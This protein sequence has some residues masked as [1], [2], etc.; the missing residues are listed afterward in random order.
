M[1]LTKIFPHLTDRR[2]AQLIN[3]SVDLEAA[4]A[5]GLVPNTLFTSAKDTF[6]RVVDEGSEK[7]LQSGPKFERHNN[8]DWWSAAYANNAFVSGCH[9]INAA[10]KRAR[11][12]DDL[13]PYFEFLRDGLL[14][15]QTLLETA[16]PLVRKKADMPKQPTKREQER[17]GHEMTCQCCGRGIFA[18]TGKIAHHGYE[19][20]GHGWQTGSCVGALELPFE[21][22]RER[23]HTLITS[24]EVRRTQMIASRRK[25]MSERA[26]VKTTVYDL[27][28][29]RGRDGKHPL[30]QLEITR[31][32][33]ADHAKELQ[34][35]SFD[36]LLKV[37]VDKRA[38]DIKNI[39]NAIA[40]QQARFDGWKQTHERKGNEWVAL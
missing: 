30:K 25:V 36:D 1:D 22:S 31:D 34:Y 15:L 37:A 26:P 38:R 3:A 20:P 23:L 12:I 14:P 5:K 24:W 21:V 16:K 10:M 6:N 13:V 39:T 9:G 29:P 17:K 8:S 7:F 33:F 19:R 28:Q 35:A 11:K 2:A 18:N 4:V 27:S 40:E 32:N